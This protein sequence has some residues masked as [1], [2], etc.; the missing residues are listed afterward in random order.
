[1]G[2]GVGVGVG[3]DADM[4]ADV[5]EDAW[6]GRADGEGG[7][8]IASD[9]TSANRPNMATKLP[10]RGCCSGTWRRGQRCDSRGRTGIPTGDRL[11]LDP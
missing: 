1:M 8:R 11:Q 6:Q 3:V 7:T 2:V 4:D 5:D 10:T 9:G